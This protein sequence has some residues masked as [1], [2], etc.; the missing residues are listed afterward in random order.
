MTWLQIQSLHLNPGLLF[1]LANQRKS[2]QKE[3]SPSPGRRPSRREFFI[4]RSLNKEPNKGLSFFENCVFLLI[5]YFVI[6]V[7][8]F[9]QILL[10]KI[11]DTVNLNI[12]SPFCQTL[13]PY[14]WRKTEARISDTEGTK[15]RKLSHF[16]YSQPIPQMS[17]WNSVALIRNNYPWTHE[18]YNYP[19]RGSRGCRFVGNWLGIYQIFTI[20]KDG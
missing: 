15:N 12:L 8:I 5:I 14:G 6:C 19:D 9:F 7:V 4:H 18:H 1:A 16:I 13:R 20:N 17:W 10:L 2:S 11:L 3:N